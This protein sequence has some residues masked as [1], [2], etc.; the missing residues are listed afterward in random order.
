[1]SRKF[2]SLCAF[3]GHEHEFTSAIVAPPF[4]SVEPFIK[5][6]D[7]SMCSRCGNVNVLDE[8]EMLRRPTS[9]E[10]REL[11]SDIRVIALRE[12]LHA[13]KVTRQ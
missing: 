2:S 6:G 7:A 3:C 12:A 9:A 8:N 4:P 11:E 13:A 5:P 1:M 10:S